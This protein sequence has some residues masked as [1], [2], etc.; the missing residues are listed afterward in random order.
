MYIC[1]NEFS[2]TYPTRVWIPNIKFTIKKEYYAKNIKK[3]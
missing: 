2:I 1:K 3:Q